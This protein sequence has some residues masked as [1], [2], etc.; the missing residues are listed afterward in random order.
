MFEIAKVPKD[1][2]PPS[3]PVAHVLIAEDGKFFWAEMALLPMA[4]NEIIA[5]YDNIIHTGEWRKMI[6]NVSQS[7]ERS[8]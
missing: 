3:S 2:K 5:D 1:L 4:P 6:I 8:E 7:S